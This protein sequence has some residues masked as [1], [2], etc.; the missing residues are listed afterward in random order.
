M[1]FRSFENSKADFIDQTKIAKA[2]YDFEKNSASNEVEAKK[3]EENYQTAIKKSTDTF[4]SKVKEDTD[5]I[6]NN[7]PEKVVRKLETRVKEEKKESIETQIR[8]HL[9]GFSRT[10]PSFIMAYGDDKL[11][12][13]NFDDYTEDDVFEEVTGITE[14]DF[15]FLRDGGVYFNEQTQRNEYFHGHLF[16]EVVFNDSIKEFLRKKK[17]LNNYFDES[18]TEDIFDYIPPQKTNQIYTPKKE[19]GRAHV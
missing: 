9:R 5:R 6:I 16:D 2:N 7:I 11:T 12:L 15:R 1:L 3:A 17:E 8:D 18:L 19:I 14:E 10:I 13:A 4:V